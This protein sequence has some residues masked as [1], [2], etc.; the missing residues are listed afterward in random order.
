MRPPE[1]RNSSYQL[2]A[3]GEAVEEV[4]LMSNFMRRLMDMMSMSWWGGLTGVMRKAR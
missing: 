3:K 2:G 4:F 1:A